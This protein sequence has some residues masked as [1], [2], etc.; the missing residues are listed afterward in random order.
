MTIAIDIRARDISC[1][2]HMITLDN[3]GLL[4]VIG[5]LYSFSLYI[6]AQENEY[7]TDVLTSSTCSSDGRT[8]A[9]ASYRY[10]DG[11]RTSAHTCGVGV[12]P[13]GQSVL[14]AARGMG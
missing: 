4:C 7:R 2:G 12:S 13:P 6:Q 9:Q 10:S 11:R 14:L 1:L 3:Q 8:P 5:N